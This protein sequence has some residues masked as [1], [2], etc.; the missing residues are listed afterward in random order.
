[1]RFYCEALHRSYQN[2]IPGKLKS[3]LQVKEIKIEDIEANNGEMRVWKEH[4]FL[5]SLFGVEKGI[6]RGNIWQVMLIDLSKAFSVV[7]IV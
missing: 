2:T 6:I 5:G 4:A 7:M 1:M 3:N